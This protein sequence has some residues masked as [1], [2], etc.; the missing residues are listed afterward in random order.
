[1][2]VLA[3]LLQACGG[4]ATQPAG[5]ETTTSSTPAEPSGDLVEVSL[6]NIAFKPAELT[7][8]VGTTVR[9]LQND[10]EIPH[11]V[12]AKAE[13]A[14]D[15]DSGTID[16]GEVF[17][18]TFDEPGTFPYFCEIHPTRM[19]GVVTVVEAGSNSDSSSG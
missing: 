13:T 9:F 8:E 18:V 5:G 6:E 10:G 16:G 17:E 2:A 1:M 15:F 14:G 4:P 7:V 3:L 11:T 12:T 19:D